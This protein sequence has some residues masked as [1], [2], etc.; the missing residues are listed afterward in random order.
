ME[1]SLSPEHEHELPAGQ[2]HLVQLSVSGESVVTD[3]EDRVILGLKEQGEV[4][5][6]MVVYKDF[7]V[8]RLCSQYFGQLYQARLLSIM[9][10]KPHIPII[11]EVKD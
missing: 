8:E 2:E 10:S 11:H 3:V 6:K 9:I 4:G 7:T 1:E 5:G